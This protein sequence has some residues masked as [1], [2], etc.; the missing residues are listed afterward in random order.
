MRPRNHE[1]NGPIPR[2]QIQGT[3]VQTMSDHN[4]KSYADTSRIK[5][6]GEVLHPGHPSDWDDT[7]KLSNLK[8]SIFL[9]GEVW[10][11]REN[12]IDANRYCRNVK[13]W[14]YDLIGGDQCAIVCKG[15]CSQMTFSN[16]LIEP[17]IKARYDIEIDGWSDQS[18]DTSDVTLEEIYRKDGKPVRVVFGRFVKPRIIGGNCKI[19]WFWT[20]LLHAYNIIKGIFK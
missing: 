16:I 5:V 3:L 12:A 1:H 14:K 2:F 11:G 20:I 18:R 17:S 4:Y 10:G 6:S 15:G 9:N 19:S 7:M 8:D 13:V